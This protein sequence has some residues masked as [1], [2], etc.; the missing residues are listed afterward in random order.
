MS[1]LEFI[2][3]MTSAL[4]WPTVAGSALFLLRRQIKSAATQLVQRVSDIRRVK[5]P[6]VDVEF[7]R[8]VQELT[9]AS[10][11]LDAEVVDESSIGGVQDLLL[12]PETPE[13]RLNKY[14]RLAELDP[15]AA[16]LSS[17]ADLEESLQ[18]Y[19]LA[20][21]PDGQQV[22]GF[23]RMLERLHSDG[24]IDDDI[25]STFTDLNDDRNRAAHD[26]NSRGDTD[27]ANAYVRT[28]Q[29]GIKLLELMRMKASLSNI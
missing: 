11:T 26:P 28:I 2:A 22:S 27:I 6:G 10:Q 23:R 5:A 15:K 8:R 18:Q 19:F 24:H 13:Q 7:E 25:A 16:I 14:E 12:P 1:V 29:S 20:I 17:F 9:E 3:Q 4:A 21:Y